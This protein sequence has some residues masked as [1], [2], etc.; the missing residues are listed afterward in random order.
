[1]KLS[2][3]FL[4]VPSLAISAIGSSIFSFG[5]GLYLLSLTGK[6]GTFA[7]NLIL[8]ALPS[9]LLG[10][11]LGV[12][13]DRVSKKKIII[14]S[15]ILNGTLML[16]LYLLWNIDLDKE[17]LIYIA[18]F[19]TNSLAFVVMVAFSSSKPEFFHKSW[20]LKANSITNTID[21]ISNITGPLLGG[22]IY[23]LLG[24]EFFILINGISFFIS[25]IFECFLRYNL[26][27]KKKHNGVNF[28]NGIK[29][30]IGSKE[31][32]LA[33]GVGVLLNLAQGTLLLIPI[34][35]TLKIIFGYS[36]RVYGIIQGL[37]PLGLVVNSLVVTRSNKGIDIYKVHQV[38]FGFSFVG[39]IFLLP[40]YFN[41]SPLINIMVYS[42]GMFLFGYL[43][44]YIN[45]AVMTTLQK[46]SRSDLIG[47]VIG[48]FVGIVRLILPISLYLGGYLVDI[49]PRYS[50]IAGIFTYTL[51]ALIFSIC[52]RRKSFMKISN[53]LEQ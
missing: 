31:L 3:K 26:L 50:F 30:I 9:I 19:L 43:L 47:Q 1:M 29:S 53:Q 41:L 49:T 5:A 42:V 46:E 33:L 12:I 23:L 17:L 4:I 22:V 27:E 21:S 40:L 48:N 25:A 45:V 2:N 10:P 14:L 38:F 28:L 52:L 20:L 39:V 7:T 36:D 8:W 11:F 34:P 18:T 35:Y 13:I 6:G 44:L 51:G 15:D 37:L 24:F 32:S 16:S